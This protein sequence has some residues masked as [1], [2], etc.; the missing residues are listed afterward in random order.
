MF[1]VR[2]K[3]P[4]VPLA[5]V[6][7]LMLVIVAGLVVF[8]AAT[9]GFSRFSFFGIGNPDVCVENVRTLGS[10]VGHTAASVTG[11]KADSSASLYSVTLCDSKPGFGGEV[12]AGLANAP[13][14]LVLIG[15]LIYLRGSISTARRS[16]LFTRELARRIQLLGVLLIGGIAVASGIEYLAGVALLRSMVSGTSWLDGP[17]DL[18]L[19]GIV[20]G[21]GIVTVGLILDRA[22]ILQDDADATI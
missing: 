7:D 10:A 6:V 16:G 21:F 2:T 20:A 11:L 22:V 18:S 19:V 15:F 8:F 5:V 1:E 9:A 13:S 14:T 3:D 12:L 17:V 4:L